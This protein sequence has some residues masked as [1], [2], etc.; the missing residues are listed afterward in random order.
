MYMKLFILVFL[1]SAVGYSATLDCKS[2][3]N[4]KEVSHSSIVTSLQ[5]K[6]LVN[7]DE[8][9]S[10]YVTETSPNVFTLEAFI[11]KLEIRIYSKAILN[12]SNELLTTSLWDRDIMVDVECKNIK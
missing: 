9:V 8:Q 7:R 10:S 1:G 12:N 11:P 6:I 2:V 5:N 4:L 3:V